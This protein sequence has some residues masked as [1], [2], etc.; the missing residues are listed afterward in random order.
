[1]CA[2]VCAGCVCSVVCVQCGV[3]VLGLCVCGVMYVCRCAGCGCVCA[4]VLGVVVCVRRN[5]IY[6]YV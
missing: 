4:G 6:C 3:G 5:V 1:V 2:F